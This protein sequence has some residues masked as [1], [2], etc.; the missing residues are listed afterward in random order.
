MRYAH[1]SPLTAHIVAFLDVYETMLVQTNKTDVGF[2]WILGHVSLR[3]IGFSKSQ[4]QAST[5]LLTNES[6]TSIV[7]IFSVATNKLEPTDDSVFVL[8]D[9]KDDICTSL[10]ILNTSSFHLK[11]FIPLLH[12][13][14][15]M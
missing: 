1:R 12:N 6:G 11:I 15:C 13:F 2:M 10:D 3:V 9:S 7:Q 5:V 4:M 14:L 8:S